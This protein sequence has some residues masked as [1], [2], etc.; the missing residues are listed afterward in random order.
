[1]AL[2]PLRFAV[3]LGALAAIA[4]AGESDGSNGPPPGLVE[5]DVCLGED[6]ECSLSFRQLRHRQQKQEVA[7]VVDTDSKK[8]V[9]HVGKEDVRMA[10]D[11]KAGFSNHGHHHH[12]HHHHAEKQL[13]WS[14]Q[15]GMC[16]SVDGN[17]FKNGQKMQLWECAAGMGQYFD[18]QPTTPTTLL[19]SAAAPAFCV[20]VDGNKNHNGAK[21]QLWACDSSSEAQQ[22]IMS[23]YDARNVMLKNAAFPSK[24]LVVNGN[25]GYNG[26]KLQMWDCAGD[27]E[28]KL[29][30]PSN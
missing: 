13:R 25:N 19:R 11:S 3:L 30:K 14:H 7:E 9:E 8:E 26:N 4:F 15:P 12:G 6:E 18:Y 2:A 20:V 23:G 1:M 27:E 10:E 29:W 24:C 5:D 28:Q 17:T 21:V 16:M 22:W